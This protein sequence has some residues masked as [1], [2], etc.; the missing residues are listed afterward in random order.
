[1]DQVFTSRCRNEQ[2]L[3]DNFAAT[4]VFAPTDI[5]IVICDFQYIRFQ[6]V[7]IQV[8]ICCLAN[9]AQRSRKTFRSTFSPVQKSFR[10][11]QFLLAKW[12]N[13]QTVDRPIW[14]NW[15]QYY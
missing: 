9:K 4:P 1:M 7:G 8:S 12:C 5:A 15:V 11:S 2:T 6:Q 3:D 13:M 14:E 10:T